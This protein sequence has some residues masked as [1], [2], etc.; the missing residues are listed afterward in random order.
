MCHF[1]DHDEI[2]PLSSIS[3]LYSIY[4]TVIQQLFHLSAAQLSW[5]VCAQVN[6]TW[7]PNAVTVSLPFT[8]LILSSMHFITLP[9]Y[10]KDGYYIVR[11]F[12]NM[13]I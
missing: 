13:I 7:Q 5:Y 10:N 1:V 2:I 9:Y 8:S 11:Y 3:P 4:P 6:F 12:E